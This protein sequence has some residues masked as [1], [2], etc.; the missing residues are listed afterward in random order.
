MYVVGEWWIVFAVLLSRKPNSKPGFWFDQAE[1]DG[2][3][4]FFGVYNF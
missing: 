1:V 3:S 4:G 2:K